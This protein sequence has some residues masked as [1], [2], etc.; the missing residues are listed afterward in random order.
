MPYRIRNLEPHLEQLADDYP[1]LT[2]TGPRQSGKTTLCRHLFKGLDYVSLEPL[3]QREYA[4]TDPRGFLNE[5]RD[6]AVIDEIQNVPD[7]ASYLQEEVDRDARPGRF[8]LTG[9]QNLAVTQAVSQSLAG[10]AA[11]CQLLPLSLDE[12]TR[13]GTGSDDLF[14]TLTTGGYPRIHDRNLEARRWLADYTAT[15]IERDVRQISNVENLEAFTRFVALAAGRTGQEINLTSLGSDVGV[16]HNTARAWL[17][18]LEA[19]FLVFRAKPWLRNLR[20]QLVKSPKLH[21]LDSGLICSLLGI[22]TPE[23]LRHHPLRGAIFES[24]VTSEIRKHLV[25]SG[26]GADL[27]HFRESRGL[28]VDIL[29][30]LPDRIIACEA[31][32]AETYDPSFSRT[33]DRFEALLGRLN[34]PPLTEKRVV[35]GGPRGQRRKDVTV[36]SWRKIHAADWNR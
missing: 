15:Y 33:L 21:F 17:S 30:Q 5:Y 27:F 9:S 6:G 19:S 26:S 25:N 31:K 14:E 8:V 28:E 36:L 7:L 2:L 16:S 35:F 23:E 24:W 18:V 34:S 4:R 13:F 32:S 12:I 22:R 20:K 10:R 3:D 29:L 11:I 1:V